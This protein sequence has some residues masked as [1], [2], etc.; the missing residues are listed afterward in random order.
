ML[1]PT[2]LTEVTASN[3]KEAQGCRHI[4]QLVIVVVVKWIWSR[5]KTE[6]I[7]YINEEGMI[8]RRRYER[9][10]FR[11]ATTPLSLQCQIPGLFLR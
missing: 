10:R 4:P 2:M 7:L 3:D 8:E 5:W 9:L 1:S 11:A 6:T